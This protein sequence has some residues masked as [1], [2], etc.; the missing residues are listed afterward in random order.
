MSV[1][2]VIEVDCATRL[3]NLL[4]AIYSYSAE[5]STSKKSDQIHLYLR[6][7]N[8][9]NISLKLL[10]LSIK[11]FLSLLL[12][13][14]DISLEIGLGPLISLSGFPLSGK[15]SAYTEAVLKSSE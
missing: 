9:S 14:L 11:T 6:L 8:G 5:S 7:S 12:E 1:V 4:K 10:D 15:S 3:L 13:L 2:S